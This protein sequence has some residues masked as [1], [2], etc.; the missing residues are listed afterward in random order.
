[1]I[2]QLY[3][4]IFGKDAVIKT[5]EEGSS[6]SFLLGVDNPEESAYLAWVEAGNQPLPAEEQA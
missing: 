1:M 3:K 6:S 2:Y 4:T 5:N